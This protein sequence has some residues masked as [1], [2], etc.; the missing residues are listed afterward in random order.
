M[1]M[2]EPFKKI[3]YV[4]QAGAINYIMRRIDRINYMSALDNNPSI[5]WQASEARNSEEI[6]K[7]HGGL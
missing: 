1:F 5:G 2:A 3:M 7:G 4:G 6:E